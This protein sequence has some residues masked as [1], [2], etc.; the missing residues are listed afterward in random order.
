[1]KI[2][3]IA[4]ANIA[5]KPAR[6]A[7][8]AALV[9][10]S[11]FF[12]FAA[13]SLNANLA[14]NLSDLSGRLGADSLIV[15]KGYENSTQSILLRGEPGTFY[16]P[17]ALLR[18]IADNISGI[19]RITPQFFLASFD[20]DCCDAKVQIIGFDPATDFIITP[21]AVQ[22]DAVSTLANG[23]I[24]VGSRINAEP[25]ETLLF[26]SYRYLVK[27][28]LHPTGLGLDTSIF[29]PLSGVHDIIRRTPNLLPAL[30]ADPAAYISTIA[31][32]TEPGRS[33]YDLT[34]DI[35]KRYRTSFAIQAIETARMVT[36]IS[37]HL[38]RI[39]LFI[40]ATAAA[41][42]LLAILTLA[43][44]FTLTLN[45]RKRELSLLR[46]LGAPRRWVLR[47]IT[48]EAVFIG[49]FGTLL[50][51]GF[52]ALTLTLFAPLIFTRI[53]LPNLTLTYH[54]ALLH[55]LFTMIPSA[56]TGVLA[57]AWAAYRITR[58]DTY[59]T[60]REGE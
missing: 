6:S 22:K 54:A 33:S 39:S 5:R 23:E 43:L 41:F 57:G 16:M 53:G 49:L 44:V 28:K 32:K 10:L 18:L 58:S 1:M 55:A 34:T 47:L 38:K 3:G 24:A 40:H 46:I 36:D 17:A 60:L 56:A 45:E 11:A 26:Y 25:G 59:N 19:A 9:A 4:L 21:W 2:S 42:W 29:M 27:A 14:E 30:A 50:G 8:L 31:I 20:S 51:I 7:A 13:I 15:P 37:A 12:L 35:L 48:A 52:A